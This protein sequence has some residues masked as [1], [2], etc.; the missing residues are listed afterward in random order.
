MKPEDVFGKI[1][2]PDF[3]LPLT[4]RGGAGGI[5]FFLTKVV[6]LIYLVAGIIFLFMVIISAFQWMLSGGDKEAVSKARG[7]LTWAIIG[8]VLLALAFVI[9]RVIGQ[10]IG[11]KFFV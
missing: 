6:E 3:L 11:F 5:S 10:I 2:P 8:I 1:T 7:R 9:I 4:N